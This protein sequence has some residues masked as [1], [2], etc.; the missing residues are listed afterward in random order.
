MEKLKL[1]L[2]NIAK[3]LMSILEQKAV[4]TAL[5]RLLGSATVGG[6]RAWIITYLIKDILFEKALEPVVKK[7]LLGIGYKMDR[8]EGGFQWKKLEDAINTGDDDA[9]DE[10]SDDITG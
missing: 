5:I 10:V 3:Y 1:I 8:I 7:T 2:S 4:K 6:F 9:Y